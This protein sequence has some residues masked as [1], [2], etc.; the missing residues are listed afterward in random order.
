[1]SRAIE[2]RIAEFLANDNPRIDWVKPAVREHGFLPLYLGWVATLGLRPDG[3]FVRWNHEADHA[4]VEPLRDGYWKRMAICQGAKK[5][6]E[7]A[8]LLP[9]RPASRRPAAYAAALANQAVHPRSSAS[10]AASAGSSLTKNRR[11]HQAKRVCVALFTSP[12]A[13]PSSRR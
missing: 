2:I 8:A 3:S 11:S 1:M 4:S 12:K 13:G 9:E 5:Y 10:A 6:P 7:L